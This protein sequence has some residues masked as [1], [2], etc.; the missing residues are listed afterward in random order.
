M[1]VGRIHDNDLGL[2]FLYVIASHK[3]NL[4]VSL[5]VEPRHVHRDLPLA[6]LIIN[7]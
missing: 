3:N 1:R 7:G 5:G 2:E 6:V 4:V